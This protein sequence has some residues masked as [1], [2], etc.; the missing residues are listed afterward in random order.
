MCWINPSRALRLIVSNQI[1][2][3]W[4]SNSCKIFP[5]ALK[6]KLQ[7]LQK[8][9]KSKKIPN[10]NTYLPKLGQNFAECDNIYGRKNMFLNKF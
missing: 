10:K 2:T 8:L 3:T 5:V 9:L 7:S 6:T 4:G 1:H